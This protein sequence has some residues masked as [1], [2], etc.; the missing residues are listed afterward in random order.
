MR[1]VRGIVLVVASLV[2]FAGPAVAAWVVDEHGA[3]VEQWQSGD[4]LRGPT[5]VANVPLLPVR[6]AIGGYRLAREDHTPGFESKMLLP[7]MLILGGGA[8]GLAEGL[9]WLG[10]GMADTLTGGVFSIAPDEATR[11][12]VAPV[13]PAFV[14]D[15]V[16]PTTDACGRPATASR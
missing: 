4:L 9:L 14:A 6:S 5:A 1:D 13:R 7:P 10:T 3:C 16:R 15:P 8:M 11:L 12:S 2:A